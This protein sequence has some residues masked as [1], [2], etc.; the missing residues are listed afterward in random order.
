MDSS[1]VRDEWQGLTFSIVNLGHNVQ[2]HS[3]VLVRGGRSQDCPGVR[4][5]LVRGAFDLVRFSISGFISDFIFSELTRR[6]LGRCGTQGDVEIEIWD[7]E[8]E[9]GFMMDSM[10]RR[11]LGGEIYPNCSP[12]VHLIWLLDLSTTLRH[13][14]LTP[15]KSYSC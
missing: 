1:F 2:Q 8:S 13:G 4:Y 9:D 11:A 10:G 5:H 14:I 15:S 6:V 12:F 7:E 3:V